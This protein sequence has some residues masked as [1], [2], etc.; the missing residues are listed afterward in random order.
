MAYGRRLKLSRS[1]SHPVTLKLTCC[2]LVETRDKHE[3]IVDR[4]GNFFGPV[5]FG[6]VTHQEISPG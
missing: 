6:G 5:D 3:Q 4:W 1:E 2:P